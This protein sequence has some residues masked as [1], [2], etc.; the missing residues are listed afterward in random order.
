MDLTSTWMVL[1]MGKPTPKW[2]CSERAKTPGLIASKVVATE[3]AAAL[4]GGRRLL[5]DEEQLALIHHHVSHLYALRWLRT[6]YVVGGC[7]C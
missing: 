5:L 7:G 1:D 6:V 3:P 4:D 2:H